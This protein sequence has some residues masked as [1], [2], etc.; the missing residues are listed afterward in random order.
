MEDGGQWVR[1]VKGPAVAGRKGWL[2][3]MALEKRIKQLEKRVV[4]LESV[5]GATMTIVK[6]PSG[7]SSHR[8]INL[9]RMIENSEM[10]R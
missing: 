3:L 2:K 1:A 10:R 5:Q 4:E 8:K 7:D 9:Q 6:S